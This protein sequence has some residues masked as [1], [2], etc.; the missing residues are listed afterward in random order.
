MGKFIESQRQFVSSAI[1]PVLK[2]ILPI[3]LVSAA[4]LFV[5][6]TARSAVSLGTFVA[7]F[8]VILLLLLSW[9]LAKTKRI[10]LLDDQ[11]EISNYSHSQAVEC[12][13]I[14][15]MHELRLQNFGYVTLNFATPTDFGSSVSFVVSYGL[16]GGTSASLDRL[17]SRTLSARKAVS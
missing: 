6:L 3:L 2:F 9:C 7:V 8:V 17:R 14:S 1:T 10:L 5:W 16:L 12:R 13:M 4:A 11:I 15:S